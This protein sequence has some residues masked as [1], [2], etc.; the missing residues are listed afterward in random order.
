MTARLRWT[1]PANADFLG[2]VEWIKT[3]NPQAAAASVGGSWMRSK[4]SLPFER[5]L[6]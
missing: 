3:R 2:I 6:D 5:E 4:T 1:I